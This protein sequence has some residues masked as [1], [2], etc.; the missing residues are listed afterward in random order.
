MWVRLKS[1]LT[2]GTGEPELALGNLIRTSLQKFFS[3]FQNG[4]SKTIHFEK[5]LEH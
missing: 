3:L 4:L 2:P 1:P 5:K